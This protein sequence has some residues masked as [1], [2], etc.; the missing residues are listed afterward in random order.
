MASTLPGKGKKK[1]G[2]GHQCKH[3]RANFARRFSGSLDTNVIVWSLAHPF[4]RVTIKG[5]LYPDFYAQVPEFNADMAQ[6][7]TSG[8]VTGRET[9]KEGLEKTPEAFLGLFSGE[10]TGKMLVK[11]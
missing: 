3:A 7:I 8:A 6:L 1:I 2:S 11:L 5:F 10:N 4:K 9:V